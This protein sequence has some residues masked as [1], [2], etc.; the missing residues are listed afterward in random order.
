M[1]KRLLIIDDDEDIRDMLKAFFE[2]S[3]Y[4]VSTLGKANN[5]FDAYNKYQPDLILLDYKM[6]EENG[7]KICLQL[8]SNPGT[9][10]IP[11]I[12][13]SGY[14]KSTLERDYHGWNG[15]VSKP[16]DLS[17]LEAMV[18]KFLNKPR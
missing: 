6:P 12:M 17:T 4:I 1:Q 11:I 7:D 5:I 8:K 10:H 16:F 3:D 14:P 13:I 18:Q 15:I 9:F 2:S